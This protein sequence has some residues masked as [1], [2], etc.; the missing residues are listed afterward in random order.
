MKPRDRGETDAIVRRLLGYA[1]VF[2]DPGEDFAG[3]RMRME[4]LVVEGFHDLHKRLSAGEPVPE[5]WDPRMGHKY[6]LRVHAA[7]YRYTYP[8]GRSAKDSCAS[9]DWID[10]VA[11]ESACRR[12]HTIRMRLDG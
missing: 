1:R 5:V 4:G 12:C 11:A 10:R 2:A 9:C 6:R 8:P 3:V 7:S